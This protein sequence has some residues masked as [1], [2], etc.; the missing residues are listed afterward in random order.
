MYILYIIM[1]NFFIFIYIKIS[2][3]TH[4]YYFILKLHEICQ[5]NKLFF[6]VHEQPVAHYLRRFPWEVIHQEK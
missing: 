3:L 1:L 6:F 4:I 2:I 5:K